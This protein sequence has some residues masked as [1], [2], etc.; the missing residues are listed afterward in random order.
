MG[1][2]GEAVSAYTGGT[3]TRELI[4]EKHQRPSRVD[5]LS[6]ATGQ[7]YQVQSYVDNFYK[8]VDPAKISE[9]SDVMRVD[10][11]SMHRQPELEKYG[12]DTAF[13]DHQGQFSEKTLVKD[14]KAFCDSV[15][16]DFI[17]NDFLNAVYAKDEILRKSG[18]MG[19]SNARWKQ[20]GEETGFVD[21]LRKM[22]EKRARVFSEH[23]MKNTP[24][25]SG[26]LATP[27]PP[28]DESAV[29]V[30]LLSQEAGL[31]RSDRLVCF[32]K[33]GLLY[34]QNLDSKTGDYIIYPYGEHGV[35]C[36]CPDFQHRRAHLAG[37]VQPSSSGVCKHLKRLEDDLMKE[38]IDG[39]GGPVSGPD[40]RR[41]AQQ[42]L[43]DAT[44][45]LMMESGQAIMTD[46]GDY[47][48]SKQGRKGFGV[49]IAGSVF[50]YRNE[51]LD[52]IPP[53]TPVHLTPVDN[54][55]DRNAVAIMLTTPSARQAAR[56]KAQGLR[57]SEQK[58]FLRGL[59]VRDIGEIET[60]PLCFGFLPRDY[61]KSIRKDSGI[62]DY[63]AKI[64]KVGGTL[65]GGELIA[66][67]R[68]IR[69]KSTRR[70]RSA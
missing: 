7:T 25:P 66:V 70:P 56:E 24:P 42:I 65:K 12:I 37:G 19:L 8:V 23:N 38:G 54:P 1:R 27:I 30:V 6:D 53:G 5:V 41:Q 63:T 29:G 47:I 68:K 16:D 58:M 62:S 51:L 48:P 61:A 55:H 4:V 57:G 13:F 32:E 36:T 31:G 17:Q 43:R 9:S 50:H 34:I 44:G 45:R 22:D 33:G 49:P 18:E 60:Q 15:P 10:I 64:G 20:I 69:K 2:R 26:A 14:L 46:H 52:R 21:Y 11:A 67:G 3:A 39:I 28:P 40:K 35:G 59:G